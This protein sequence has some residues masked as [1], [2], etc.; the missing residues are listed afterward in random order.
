LTN[1]YV[2]N[3]LLDWQRLSDDRSEAG[4]LFVTL[5]NVYAFST[6]LHCVPKKTCDHVFDDK[7]N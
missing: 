1:R 7:L 5:F 6:V 3:C 4:S 2:F